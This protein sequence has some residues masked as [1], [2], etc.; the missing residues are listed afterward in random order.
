MT[1]DDC[2]WLLC[3]K[4]DW[5][6]LAQPWLVPRETH[7][8]R[9]RHPNQGV[10]TWNKIGD[11]NCSTQIISHYNI[12]YCSRLEAGKGRSDWW[13]VMIWLDFWWWWWCSCL[14]RSIPCFFQ[15]QLVTKVCWHLWW[16][17]R[18]DVRPLGAARP[19][20]AADQRWSWH[21][22]LPHLRGSHLDWSDVGQRVAI[23]GFDM[24]RLSTL[25]LWKC[26]VA[27]AKSW[28][29]SRPVG[30]KLAWAWS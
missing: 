22:S 7:Y 5:S 14:S 21:W 20:H 23:H 8:S 4:L 29:A 26:I 24:L 18:L 28:K 16:L 13:I 12:V 1:L 25:E 30:T 2:Q 11:R 6:T 9:S 19:W 15:P 17:R 3:Q 27:I 10:V